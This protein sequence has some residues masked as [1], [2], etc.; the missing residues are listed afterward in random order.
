MR[1]ICLLL[2]LGC[3]ERHPLGPNYRPAVPVIEWGAYSHHDQVRRGQLS[4]IVGRWPELVEYYW[5]IRNHVG[6]DTTRDQV[7]QHAALF[8]AIWQGQRSYLQLHELVEQTL[9]HTSGIAPAYFSPLR[10]WKNY[11]ELLQDLRRRRVLSWEAAKKLGY[12]FDHEAD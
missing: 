10:E 6:W 9:G 7:L 2:L 12:I 3:A 8:E 11:V 5:A 1:A 4:S